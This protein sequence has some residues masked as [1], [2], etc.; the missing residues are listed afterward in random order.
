MI[1][2]IIFLILAVPAGF[3]IAL[4]CEDE[5]VQ[6]KKVFRALVIAGIALGLFFFAFGLAHISLTCFF[7]TIASF[8]SYMKGRDKTIRNQ[9]K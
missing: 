1:Y 5:L 8:I 7:I 6:G 3:L 9:K 2:E 4:L